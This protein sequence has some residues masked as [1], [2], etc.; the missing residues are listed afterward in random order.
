MARTVHKT[1][2]RNQNSLVN[3]DIRIS[4]TLQISL[5]FSCSTSIDDALALAIFKPDY[6]NPN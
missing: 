3:M 1:P 5:G 4:K 6:D 2:S